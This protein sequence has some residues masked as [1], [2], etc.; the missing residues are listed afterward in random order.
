MGV[1]RKKSDHLCLQKNRKKLVEKLDNLG[2]TEEEYL[3]HKREEKN[4]KERERRKRK[5]LEL[6]ELERNEEEGNVI[7][8]ETMGLNGGHDHTEETKAK[9]GLANK[10]NTPWNK[11]KACPE[12]TKEKSRSSLLAN[13]RKKLLEK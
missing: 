7:L 11:G 2:I 13:N 3:Q 9:I 4:E 5:K 1:Q 6:A 8:P 10:G 12:S